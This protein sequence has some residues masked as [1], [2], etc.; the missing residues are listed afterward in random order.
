MA[1]QRPRSLGLALCLLAGILGACAAPVLPLPPP[2]ALIER[3]PD[4]DGI[5]TVTG[6]GRPGVFIACLNENT[7]AGVLVRA[8]V[9]TGAFEARLPG[10]AGD[11]IRIWQFEASDAG[12]Q[13]VFRTVPSP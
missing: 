5:V 8:D 3:P 4:A 1:P 7:E 13:P 2:A 12:S 9:V 6:E 11:T 10:S